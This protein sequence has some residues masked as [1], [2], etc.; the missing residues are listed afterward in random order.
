MLNFP[1]ILGAALIP[2]LFGMIWYNP[3]VFGNAWM[4]ASGMDEEKA[5]GANMLVVFGLTYLFSVM[6]AMSLNFAVIHQSHI[7]SILIDEPGFKDPNS[8]IQLYL[9]DF[10]SKYGSNFRTFKHGALHGTITA[11]FLAMP[12]LGVGALFERRGFKYIAIHA[13]YWIACFAVMGGIICA[14]A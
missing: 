14:F 7:Y 9:K 4:Q 5:K 2:L 13:G 6:M 8:E 1:I 3:K 10:M 12:V 11:I